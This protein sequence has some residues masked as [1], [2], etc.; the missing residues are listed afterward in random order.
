[1]TKSLTSYDILNIDQNAQQA[2]IHRAY[3]HLA[4]TWHPDVFPKAH[5]DQA[6]HNFKL[7][8]AAY[9]DI[10]TQQARTQY[11]IRLKRLNQTVLNNQNKVMNDN[12]P[13]RAFFAK[14]DEIFQK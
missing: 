11:D 8:Q 7:L 1:M 4:K 3:R 14:L 6:H 10:K 2:D 13:L 9:N 12:N 5:K